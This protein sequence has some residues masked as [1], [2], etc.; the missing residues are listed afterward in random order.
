[1]VSVGFLNVIIMAAVCLVDIFVLFSIAIALLPFNRFMP[2]NVSIGPALVSIPILILFVLAS[3]ITF[4]IVTGRSK[5]RVSLPDILIL[6]LFALWGLSLFKAEDIIK[7]GFATFHHI[8]I[9][10]LVYFVVKRMITSAQDY[11]SFFLIFSSSITFMAVLGIVRFARTG[12]RIEVFDLS[13]IGTGLLF[14]FVSVT[15]LYSKR[16]RSKLTMLILVI[17]CLSLF[18]SF[19]RAVIALFIVSP[20]FMFALK[21]GLIRRAFLGIFLVSLFTS[22]VIPI[23]IEG[24]YVQHDDERPIE[25][26]ATETIARVTNID[27]VLYSIKRRL[28]TWKQGLLLAGEH[29][30]LGYGPQQVG[31][32]AWH[33]IYV[34]LLFW[35]GAVGV[36]LMF[37]CFYRPF[38]AP[39]GTLKMP[40]IYR[41]NL[42][43]ILAL[44]LNGNTNGYHGFAPIFIFLMIGLCE[45]LRDIK[46][47]G[48]DSQ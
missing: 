6:I 41:I 28:L 32:T 12:L 18:L 44:I 29:P 23:F 8:F 47:S 36:S 38:T 43:M 39:L 35:T 14:L 27:F 21:K 15:L 40:D 34:E 13:A 22:L 26:E 33:N 30:I 11:R 17:S 9:P 37:L 45:A 31:A 7:S 19:T 3:I 10:A 25:V 4:R 42:F 46:V 24:T 48:T 1:M 5:Y 20:I 16:Y 2:L